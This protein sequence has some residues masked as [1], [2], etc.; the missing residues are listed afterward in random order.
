M[1]PSWPRISRPRSYHA[2]LSLRRLGI[3]LLAVAGTAMS[4]T[5]APVGTTKPAE[6]EC[7]GLEGVALTNCRQLNAA[8]AGSALV[9]SNGSGTHDCAGMSGASLTTCR[10]LNGQLTA[11]VP[12]A[13]GASAVPNGAGYVTNAPAVG[14]TSSGATT[15]GNEATG[16]QPAGMQVP[17]AT[18]S[19]P[20]NS[21]APQIAPSNGQ[22]SPPTDRIVPAGTPGAAAVGTSSPAGSGAA[23]AGK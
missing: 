5:S 15:G 7:S 10:D 21:A 14:A 6:Y 20:A 23:K 11:P 17:A 3:A 8:A 19:L 16:N 12:G 4:Q 13:S 22:V 2:A 1:N 18:G 9:Q